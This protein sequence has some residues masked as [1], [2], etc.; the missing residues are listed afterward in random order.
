MRKGFGDERVEGHYIESL[1]TVMQFLP[2][3]TS[4]FI[5]KIVQ[6][7][8]NPG[9]FRYPR[10]TLSDFTAVICYVTRMGRSKV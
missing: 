5:I 8:K 6:L 1:K 9:G 10:F 7:E 4:S 2:N 3:Q